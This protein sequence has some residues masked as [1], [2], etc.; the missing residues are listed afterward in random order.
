MAHAAHCVVTQETRNISSP[1]ASLFCSSK[2]HRQHRSHPRPHPST[3]KINWAYCYHLPPSKVTPKLIDF[4]KVSTAQ[5]AVAHFVITNMLRRAMHVALDLARV[6]ELA[7]TTP[8][9]QVVP[10]GSTA[11]FPMVLRCRD[12]RTIR[13]QC[14]FCINGAHF[15]PM[16]VGA[17]L[18]ISCL[19]GAATRV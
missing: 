7:G 15:A 10:A 14:E 13:E 17:E 8:L 9:S 5:P 12:I 1:A 2:A 6:P 3:P 11:K 18:M 4:G 16:E 19:G